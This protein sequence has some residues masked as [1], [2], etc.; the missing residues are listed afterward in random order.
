MRS[1]AIRLCA[2]TAA[3]SLGLALGPAAAEAASSPHWQM[4][5]R[6][7]AA[8]SAPLQSVTAPGKKDAWAVG[9]AGSGSG[10]RP[11][12]LHWNG[13]SWSKQ[14]M[15]AGFEPSVA[16]SSSADDVWIFGSGGTK[17]MV[18]DGAGW[19]AVT[20]PDDIDP[21]AVLS[22]SD[23][24]GTAGSS[25]TGGNAAICVTTVWH[26]NGETWTSSQVK[27]LF[28]GSAAAGGHAWLV[29]LTHISDFNSRPVGYAAIY[30]SAGAA[31]QRLAAPVLKIAYPAVAASPA[32]QMWMLAGAASAKSTLLLHW[33]GRRWTDAAVPAHA[34]GSSEPFIL[35]V[36]LVY[37]GHGGVWAGPD[38]HWTGTK[39]IN[40]FPVTSPTGSDESGLDSIAVVPGSASVW[41]VGSVQRTP[42]SR[43]LD[44]L[45]EVYG[46]L[47]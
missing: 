34:A 44:S 10:A 19:A 42:R 4:D 32:G 27:G 9:V 21:G 7:H 12:A 17:A 15:P 5:Y 33:T 22:H 13:S 28:E 8:V 25:C 24:W 30:R 36:P 41:G 47:P 18:Y 26:W 35:S 20:V 31:L 6:S 45:I 38:A 40:A 43:T 46:G 11:V 29:T 23:V 39:W 37:D 2:V 3:A 16:E 14:A 1:L